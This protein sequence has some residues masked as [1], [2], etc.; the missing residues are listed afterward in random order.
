MVVES[1]SAAAVR[2]E[3]VGEQRGARRP[4]Y[5]HHHPVSGGGLTLPIQTNMHAYIHT[6]PRTRP[7]TRALSFQ[8]MEVMEVSPND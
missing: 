7:R 8:I 2:V 5:A 3:K 6:R 1:S 4:Y